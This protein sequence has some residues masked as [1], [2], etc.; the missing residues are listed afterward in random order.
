M[1]RSLINN[2]NV[3][4]VTL[5]VFSASTALAIVIDGGP[6]Y[7]P[8]GFGASG[9]AGIGPDVGSG[10]T[11]N[12]TGL[13]LGQTANLYYGIKN[14]VYVNGF[15]MD[16]G[17]ISGGEIF[18][19]DSISGNSIIYTGSTLMQFAGG[20]PD[21]VSPT[22]L[23]ITFTGT[24]AI[25]QDATTAALSNANGD[26]EALWHVMSDFSANF[27]IEA[28]VPPFDANAGNFEPGRDLFNRLNNTLNSTGSS[29]D[30]GFY[31]EIPEP[32]SI[33]L[34]SLGAL[35]LLRTGRRY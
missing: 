6:T 9:S 2:L 15:S 16:G 17:A 34:F 25:V 28:T 5:T 8:P 13:D 32:T 22:R 11:F 21:F 27:L 3:A 18:T 31:F 26:V 7:T 20:N 24:G 12:F 30:D 1:Y 14:D 10:L 33:G 29:F 35:A 23:T 4:I 19:F